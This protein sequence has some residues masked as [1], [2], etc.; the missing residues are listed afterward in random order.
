[1]KK[2][3]VRIIALGLSVSMLIGATAG[4]KKK[5]SDD[6]SSV[7]SDFFSFE[8][9]TDNT[10]N[11]TSN[12]S[13]ENKKSSKVSDKKTNQSSK[14]NNTSK[15]SYG[16]TE[17]SNGK[18]VWPKLKFKNKE[19]TWLYWGDPYEKGG[20]PK[21]VEL[22]KKQYGLSIKTVASTYFDMNT[23]FASLVMSGQSPDMVRIVDGSA[24]SFP[25]YVYKKLL[26]PVN[27]YVDFGN[28]IYKDMSYYYSKSKI[29]GKNYMLFNSASGGG[30]IVYNKKMFRDA[31]VSDP[32]K[33]YK[34][35]KWDWN[36]FAK[37]SSQL[38]ADTDGDGTIDRKAYSL[39]SADTFV[40]TTGQTFGAVDYANKKFKSNLKNASISRAV[41]FINN[42]GFTKKLGDHNFESAKDLFKNELVAMC[43]VTDNNGATYGGWNLDV[44][45]RGDL[46]LVPMPR[47]PKAKKL[48]YYVWTDATAIPVGAKNPNAVVAFNACR[49]YLAT[50][51]EEVKISDENYK[52]NCYFSD[53]NLQAFYATVNDG[54][55]VWDTV[56]WAGTTILWNAVL[57]GQSWPSRVAA[58]SDTITDKVNEAFGLK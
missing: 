23:K 52:K 46:G 37:V 45:K 19:L 58:E 32:W 29:N 28:P 20:Y 22:L 2:T 42:L 30:L 26:Q 50:N 33:L 31:G 8:E 1:M 6:T 9:N 25:G 14:K 55:P 57:M 43:I 21:M 38:V 48:Y 3:I 35:G 17:V 13:S 18:F 10:E 34:Q 5:P 4:C 7:S 16:N 53:E 51:P 27:D 12:V 54:Q 40:Y 56:S 24:G 47:D 49:R 39:G 41:D 36:A 11:E 15:K 44:A